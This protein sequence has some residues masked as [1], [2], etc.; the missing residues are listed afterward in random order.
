[1]KKITQE[2]FEKRVE[3][4]QHGTVKFYLNRK[5]IPNQALVKTKEG[6]TTR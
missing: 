4:V 6:V 5:L 1:M 2:E 3:N